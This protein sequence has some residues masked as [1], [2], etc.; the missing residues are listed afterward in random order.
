MPPSKFWSDPGAGP[1]VSATPERPRSDPDSPL[2][3]QEL[4]PILGIWVA[5]SSGI[6]HSPVVRNPIQPCVPLPPGV[7]YE[8]QTPCGPLHA[9]STGF[10]VDPAKP[11]LEAPLAPLSRD[12]NAP[13]QG[14]G[15]NTLRRLPGRKSRTRSRGRSGVRGPATRDQEARAVAG[16][17][18]KQR[19][20]ARAIAHRL[21]MERATAADRGGGGA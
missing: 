21:R 18:R 17:T 19:R 7:A 14:H 20:A 4:G 5:R 6:V 2:R 8:I 3:D 16:L 15:A 12:P 1:R 10:V 13:C 9:L 11:A